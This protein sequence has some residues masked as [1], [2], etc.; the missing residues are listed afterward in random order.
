MVSVE[1]IKVKLYNDAER[2]KIASTTTLILMEIPQEIDPTINQVAAVI[3]R[4]GENLDAAMT[5]SLANALSKEIS[6]SDEIRDTSLSL[7]EEAFNHNKKKRNPELREAA[8]VVETIFNEAFSGINIDNN[9]E[10][11]VGLDR[12]LP[13]MS[14]PEAVAAIEK[15]NLTFEMS[16]L[17]EHHPKFKELSAQRAEMKESD[18]TPRVVPSRKELHQNLDAMVELINFHVREGSSEHIAAAEKLNG[19]LSEITAL[20]KARETKKENSTAE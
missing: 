17:N 4:C 20:A 2:L 12:F 8:E 19:V 3:K 18:T 10:E 11:T 14:S 16:D 13:A 6:L 7:I 1:P 5:R 15:L 9:T